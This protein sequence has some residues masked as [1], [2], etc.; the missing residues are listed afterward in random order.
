VPFDFKNIYYFKTKM[1]EI[2]YEINIYEISQFID[3]NI[4]KSRNIKKKYDIVFY[5][6]IDN[7]DWY[8]FRKRLYM[9]LKNILKYLILIF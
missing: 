2:N 7:V 5:G 3:V 1:K 8:I 6:K 4:F 9:L